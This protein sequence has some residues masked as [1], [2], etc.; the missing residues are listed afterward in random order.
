MHSFS[1]IEEKI[2]GTI[3]RDKLA[4]MT[5]YSSNPFEMENADELLHIDTDMTIMGGNIVFQK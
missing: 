5:V 4:D 3:K 1:Y 2:K